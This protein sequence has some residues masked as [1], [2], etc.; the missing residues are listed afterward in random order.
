[1]KKWVAMMLSAIMVLPLPGCSVG[2]TSQG[3]TTLAVVEYPEDEQE[4]AQEALEEMQKEM[5]YVDAH[6]DELKGFFEKSTMSLLDSV[7]EENAVCSP[8]NV[9]MAL[10]MLAETTDGD[11]R[12]QILELL[13]MEE[14]QDL[15]ELTKAVWEQNY[16]NND[17]ICILANSLWL[18]TETAYKKETVDLLAENYY[19]SSFQGKMGS[20][21][22]NQELQGWVNQQT[23]GL[24]EEN[25]ADLAFSPETIM[26]LVSTVYLRAKWGHEFEKENTKEDI[27][28]AENGDMTCEFMN[29]ETDTYYYWG[30]KFGALKL[31]L[32]GNNGLSMWFVLPDEGVAPEQLTEE[33]QLMEV[34][35]NG[36]DRSDKKY[37]TVNLSVPKFDVASSADLK[38]SLHALGVAD[39]FDM[40]LSDFTPLTEDSKIYLSEVA[41]SARVAIDEEG[42]TAAAYTA[43]I[44]DGADMPPEEEMDFVIDRPF[45]FAITNRNNL[46]LFVGIVKNPLG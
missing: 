12:E 24:L 39:V 37:L 35:L 31:S 29:Q 26:E 30:D 27:F 1:M 9:Y 20:E 14:I 45:L 41:H 25:A 8:L 42:V 22:Y 43:E 2:E 7:K 17:S 16:S 33:G 34:L 15:R 13:G 36:W 46:P 21:E 40:N 5:E 44:G 3:V 6:E 23:G 38:E 28:H 11:S 4:E 10:S 19:A 32:L 18:D